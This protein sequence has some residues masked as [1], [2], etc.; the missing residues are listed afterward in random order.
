MPCST[1]TPP[2]ATP[3]HPER[4]LPR[5]DGGDHLHPNDAGM[6]VFSDTVDLRKLV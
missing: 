5:F 1:S 2:S 3:Q 6:K 4:M